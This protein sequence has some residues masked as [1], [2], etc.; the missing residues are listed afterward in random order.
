MCITTWNPVATD[1]RGCNQ[2]DIPRGSSQFDGTCLPLVTAFQPTNIQTLA[3]AA[4][5]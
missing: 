3:P 2:L 4:I 1:S 5:M